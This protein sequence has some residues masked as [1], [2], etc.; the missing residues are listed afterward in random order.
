MQFAD[1]MEVTGRGG[2][3]SMKLCKLEGCGRI[4]RSR[5]MCSSHY[6]R[7]RAGKPLDT[8]IRG[9]QRYE[10]DPDGKVILI[11]A[12]GAPSPRRKPFAKEYALLRSLGLR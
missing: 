11:R 12:S 7:W 5:G 6:R 4:A 3:S 2:F 9:Y 10:E 8:P 1:I